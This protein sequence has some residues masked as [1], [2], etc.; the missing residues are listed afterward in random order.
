MR[1]HHARRVTVAALASWRA[2]LKIRI[3]GR[4]KYPFNVTFPQGLTVR[5]VG[6]ETSRSAAVLADEVL[7]D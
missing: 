6:N 7:G 1:W 4:W 3:Y 2:G 5:G